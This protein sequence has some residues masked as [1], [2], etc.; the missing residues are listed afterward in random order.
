MVINEVAKKFLKVP[1]LPTLAT[2]IRLSPTATRAG[3]V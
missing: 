3:P 2:L 1:T